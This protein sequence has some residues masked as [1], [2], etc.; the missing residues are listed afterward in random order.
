MKSGCKILLSK[1]NNIQTSQF[2]ANTISGYMSP[3]FN[4]DVNKID[5][6]KKAIR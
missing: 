4:I 3:D 1:D 5:P 2:R 6:Q